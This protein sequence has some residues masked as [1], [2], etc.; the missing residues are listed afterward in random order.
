MTNTST[1]AMMREA[2]MMDA[3]RNHIWAEKTRALVAERDSLASDLAAAAEREL[4]L[5]D[6]VRRASERGAALEA[7]NADLRRVLALIR[8][9]REEC[10]AH[11]DEMGH[12]RREFD[13]DDV[14][15]ME[16][17]ARAALKETTA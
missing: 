6:D 17:A 13:A 3:S 15:L 4:A 10:H 11:D 8:D 9:H 1:K 16:Y 5:Q 14:R 7:E 2:D 12:E